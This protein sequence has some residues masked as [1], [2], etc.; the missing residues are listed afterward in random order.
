MKRDRVASIITMI[1]IA[2]FVLTI[3]SVHI[4]KV[5]RANIDMM[6]T[7]NAKLNRQIKE[8]DKIIQDLKG[9][10]CTLKDR[11][12]EINESNV[13]MS[14]E[15]NKIIGMVDINKEV[16]RGGLPSDGRP[17]SIIKSYVGKFKLSAYSL[18]ADECGKLPSDPGYGVTS[19]GK[20]VQEWHTVA[21][22]S[23]FPFGTVLYIPYFKD[24]PNHGI[25]VNED[26]GGAIHKGRID[27]YMRTKN[28]CFSFGVKNLDVY[29]LKI[30]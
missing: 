26:R 13:K 1:T 18:G 16:S 2:M 11:L 7:E 4:Q 28:Q 24:Q 19:S 23:R 29:V 12:D 10:I 3:Y 5:Y 9:Q 25:F 27:V 6:S 8:E 30:G 17:P 21:M 22:D 20:K 14:S 15:L